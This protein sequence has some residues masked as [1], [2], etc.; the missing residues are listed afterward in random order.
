MAYSNAAKVKILRVPGDVIAQF[1]AVSSQT[2]LAMAKGARELFESGFAV[3][4]TGIAGPEGGSPGKA[5]GL[6]YIAL[7]SGNH[8]EVHEYHFQGTRGAVKEQTCLA[9]LQL[10]IDFLAAQTQHSKSRS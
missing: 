7:V 4:V 6:V 1:G 2:A 8:G 5:V 10:M 3:A 9:A